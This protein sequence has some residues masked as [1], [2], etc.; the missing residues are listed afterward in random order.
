MFFRE[1]EDDNVDREAKKFRNQL[2]GIFRV[3]NLSC[4]KKKEKKSNEALRS[5]AFIESFN[6][7]NFFAFCAFLDIKF[8]FRTKIH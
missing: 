7:S 6:K 2:E 8:I 5:E 4:C 3:F 1:A